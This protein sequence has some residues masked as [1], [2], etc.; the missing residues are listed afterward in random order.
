MRGLFEIRVDQLEKNNE[1][2]GNMK[3]DA[4]L[5][6]HFIAGINKRL[7]SSEEKKQKEDGLDESHSCDG[8]Q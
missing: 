6:F 3:K 1:G 4:C 2:I 5:V 7:R 8:N